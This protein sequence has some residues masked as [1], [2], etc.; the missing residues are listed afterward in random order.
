MVDARAEVTWA[1]HVG[2][3][4]GQTTLRASVAPAAAVRQVR[5]RALRGIGTSSKRV[6]VEQPVAEN[7]IGFTEEGRTFSPPFE[8]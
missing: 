3:S 7:G 1:A 4:H 8:L 5:R 2:R 6:V